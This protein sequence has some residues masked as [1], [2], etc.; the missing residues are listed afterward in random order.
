MVEARADVEFTIY[1]Y[2]FG[3]HILGAAAEISRFAIIKAADHRVIFF[4]RVA[5]GAFFDDFQNPVSIDSAICKAFGI[6]VFHG[7]KMES[8]NNCI[9]AF[10]FAQGVE[11]VCGINDLIVYAGNEEFIFGLCFLF[12]E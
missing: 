3:Y 4:R 10:G 2:V 11:N 12:R 5:D 9:H 6:F 7:I 8:E 1:P